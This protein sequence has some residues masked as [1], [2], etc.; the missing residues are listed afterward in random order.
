MEQKE[1]NIYEKLKNIQQ[2]LKAPKG[3]YNSFGKYSYRSC[4]DIFE[5]VKP[6]LD[7]Y[8]L[9]LQA[10][11]ELVYIGE[12]YYIKATVKLIDIEKP[13]ISDDSLALMNC[14]HN[15]A[16]AREEETKKGMDGSQIT[17]ASSSYARKYALNGL[18]LI[19]DTKDSDTTNIG[20]EITKEKAEAFKF[21][22]GKHTGKTIKEL[23]KENKQ[24]LQWWLDQ[25]TNE[26]IKQMIMLI[27]DMQP[28]PIPTQEELELI[29]E[30]NILVQKTKTDYEKLL[31]HYKVK[32]NSEMTIEQ[33]KDA[34][35]LLEQKL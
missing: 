28:T 8:N 9:T 13:Y 6:L 24:Y 33:L 11:D 22:S 10:S 27:T 16:Y 7:K 30:I 29:N 12:R 25:G 4:E 35:K 5:A 26:D 15:I 19:D 3:Q 14:I 2:E 32:S 21:E 31:K 34:K 17:G 20:E 1:L 18:F 23:Y